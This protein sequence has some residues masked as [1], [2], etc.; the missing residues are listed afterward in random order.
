MLIRNEVLTLPRYKPGVKSKR[1]FVGPDGQRIAKLNS[2]EGPWPPF[3][4]A[5]E[6]MAKALPELNWYP[7]QSYA[8]LKGALAEVHH[9]EPDRIAVAAGSG[10]LIR[11]L[12]M[13]LIQPGDEVL[14]PWPPY[15]A[16]GV[17]VH[18]MG[19]IVIRVPLRDGA[20]DLDAA[21]AAITPATRL[22]LICSPHNPTGSAV[23]R[24][25][26]EAYLER[27]PDHVVTVL[28]QAYQEYVTD[29]EAVDGRHYVDG[30]KPVVVFRTFSKAYGLAG[31]RAGYSFAPVELTEAL[32]KAAETFTMSHVAVAAALASLGRQD[33]VRERAA[34]NA[35][36]RD[37][38]RAA[39][40]ERGFA[41]APTQSNFIWFDVRRNA[42]AVS[43]ALLQRGVM[44]RSGEVHDA[45]TSLRVTF[46]RPD[47]NDRFVRALDEV[48]A[49]LPEEL[50]GAPGTEGAPRAG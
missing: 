2:N 42:K 33:L 36:E 20:P 45:P 46:G 25:A 28:D 17:A 34:S 6:A 11:L 27:V 39:L 43:D 13:V 31:V 23:S 10:S 4:D 16:H 49:E 19:G 5:L 24:S 26:F 3:P 32:N 9:S 48:L 47:E 15:P 35:I 41:P 50:A 29:P 37:K 22:A 12:A 40:E 44:V 14:I 21:L 18:L 38:V 1:S 30:L 7:D 8:E